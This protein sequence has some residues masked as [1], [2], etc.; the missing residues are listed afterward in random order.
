MADGVLTSTG[1]TIE[2]SQNPD[3]ITITN[4]AGAVELRIRL[5]AEGPV[6]IASGSLKLEVENVL[7]LQSNTLDVRTTGDMRFVAGG[8][9]V[10][11]AQMIHLN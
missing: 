1:R 2:I 9:V 3:E 6:L 8:E 5:T 11:E 4:P 10:M 7:Q